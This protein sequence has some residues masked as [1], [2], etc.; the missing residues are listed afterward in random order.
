MSTMISN[1]ILTSELCP[2]C[3]NPE[4]V[5]VR[6][7]RNACGSFVHDYDCDECGGFMSIVGYHCPECTVEPTNT[8]HSVQA[9]VAWRCAC[10]VEVPA[11]YPNCF[12]CGALPPRR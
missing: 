12:R 7:G 3:D 9:D 5:E 1:G 11:Y 8:A 6:H 10:G 2:F 4:P